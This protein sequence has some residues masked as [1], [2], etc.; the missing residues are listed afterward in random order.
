MSGEQQLILEMLR[1]GKISV[2]D[3]ERLLKA[4]G[5]AADEPSPAEGAPFAHRRRRRHRP[6][7]DGGRP[8]FIHIEIDDQKEDGHQEKRRIRVPLKL[9]KAGIN[10]SGLLP[11]EAREGIAAKLKAK[12]V[13]VDPF[14][15]R[16]MDIDAFAEALSDL[17]MDLDGARI[18]IRVDTLKM[19][20]DDPDDRSESRP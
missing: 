3:A 18:R 10:L 4:L 6:G 16:G 1:G 9:L 17:D 12:G 15:L 20:E 11:R 13:E 5:N 2:D 14:E 7:N 8:R 19:D